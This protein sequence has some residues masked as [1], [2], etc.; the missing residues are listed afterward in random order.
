M[1]NE[2]FLGYL[3]LITLRT[4]LPLEV[5]ARIDNVE[6]ASE[7]AE[8]TG[9]T[10]ALKGF[11]DSGNTAAAYAMYRRL[12]RDRETTVDAW[13]YLCSAANAGNG[14]AQAEVGYW[15]RQ[16]VLPSSAVDKL[17]WT[18][19]R[20]GIQADNRIAYAWYSIAASSGN[21]QA[22]AARDYYVAPGM[23]PTDIAEAEHMADDWVPGDCPSAG[24]RLGPPGQT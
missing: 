5:L 17:A 4:N 21:T 20:V 18:Q 3:F 13:K 9:D 12:S 15:H 6:A 16:T 2:E 7:L 1:S 23:T 24:H 14:T 8:L 22:I 10:T 19:E 11:A